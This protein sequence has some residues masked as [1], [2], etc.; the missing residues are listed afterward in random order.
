MRPLAGAGSA[1]QGARTGRQAEGG[2]EG[3]GTITPLFSLGFCGFGQP[4]P[5]H[6]VAFAAIIR[7]G[8]GRRSVRVR[9]RSLRVR[10]SDRLSD[11]L[12]GSEG[13]GIAGTGCSGRVPQALDDI[14]RFFLCSRCGAQDCGCLLA[15]WMRRFMVEQSIRIEKTDTVGC[16]RRSRCASG[17]QAVFLD[18]V[19]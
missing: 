14:H 9:H 13:S 19:L 16:A 12:A 15:F 2:I 1:K 10:R 6:V 8:S 4:S 7:G 3:G 17:L 18:D 11:G 5:L